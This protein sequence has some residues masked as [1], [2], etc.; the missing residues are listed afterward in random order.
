MGADVITIGAEPNGL[1]INDHC[2]STHPLKLVEAVLQHGADLG[3]AFDGD[4]DR[5]IAIDAKGEEVDGDFILCICGDAMNRA[6]KLKEGTIVSTVMSNIGF[7]KACDSLKLK[8]A[9]RQSATATSWK[10]CAAA[11]ITWVASSLDMSFSWTTTP[12]ETAF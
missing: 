3:L 11:D 1:N 4:A 9:K 7:Y 10:K 5:L 12:Q 6:G 8:T 2:G